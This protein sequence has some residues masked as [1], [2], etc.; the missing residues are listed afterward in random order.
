MKTLDSIPTTKI[1]RASQLLKT[2][3]K[4]GGN[5]ISYY[6]EK[7]LKSSSFSFIEE[8]SDIVP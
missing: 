5:Y 3:V 4:V 7:I 2:G 1:E 8:M 6:S